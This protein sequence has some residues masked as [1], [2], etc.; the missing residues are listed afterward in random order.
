MKAPVYLSLCFSLSLILGS[1]LSGGAVTAE[2]Y[3]SLGMAYFDLGKYEDAEKWLT[4]AR[5]LDKTKAA[6]EY[7]LGRIAFELERY[8]EALRHFDRILSRDKDNVLA[9]KA[10][11]YTRLRTRDLTGAEA[12]Y[13]RVLAL[14]PESADDGYNYALILYALEKLEK[15]EELIRGYP[16]ALDENKDMLL[17]LARVQQAQGKVEALD[18]YAQWLTDNPDPKVSYEYA[19]ALEKAAYYA[20]ALE[21]YRK[22]MENFPPEGLS[23]PGGDVQK[24]GLRFIIARLLLIADSENEEGITE[25]GLALSEGYDDQEALEALAENPDISESRRADIRRTIEDAAAAAE[26]AQAAAEEEET[27]AS[28]EELPPEGGESALPEEGESPIE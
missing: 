12:L 1:C 15:A 11:A 13:D 16:F 21:E 18:S 17:L 8:D 24:P 19:G 23:G 25:L 9:L 20:R 10:A 28:T 26:K 27:A 2:E 22:L 14:V 5:L 3:Y 6:S 4:R 7:N